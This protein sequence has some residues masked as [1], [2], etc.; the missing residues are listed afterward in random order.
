MRCYNPQ[1][2]RALW[3]SWSVLEARVSVEDFSYK[4]RGCLQFG[5]PEKDLGYLGLRDCSPYLAVHSTDMQINN[6]A[7]DG[8]LWLPP[9]AQAASTQDN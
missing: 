2:C 8:T 1:F 7:L 6:Q 3:F 4:R 5:A 9:A